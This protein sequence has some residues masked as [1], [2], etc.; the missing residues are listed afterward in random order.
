MK[1]ALLHSLESG[2]I[3]DIVDSGNEFE[4]HDNF[5][6]VDVPDDTTTADRWDTENETVVK[7]NV[8]EDPIFVAHGWKVARGIAY[9]TVGDQLDMLFKEIQATGTISSTGPWATHIANVKETLPKD[10]PA[11][12]AAWNEAL[13]ASSSGNS[14]S[15]GSTP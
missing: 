14:S 11:V 9:G 7:Y 4:V 1:R 5:S 8:L 13:V 10:N 2:R 15:S 12:I 3:C 6:W